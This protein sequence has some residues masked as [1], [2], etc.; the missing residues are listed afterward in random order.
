MKT[1]AM[2]CVDGFT[3]HVDAVQ[4]ADN[5]F[6]GQVYFVGRDDTGVD[7]I[8]P[9]VVSTHAAFKKESAARIEADAY[10]LELIKSGAVL[11]LIN[12]AA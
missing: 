8:P 2:H 10:S 4:E 5:R 7:I 1:K 6:R 9:V 11:D 3:Y 12:Q